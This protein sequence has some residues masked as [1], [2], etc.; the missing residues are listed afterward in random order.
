MWKY[1][2][3]IAALLTSIVSSAAPAPA[4][5]ADHFLNGEMPVVDQAHAP[6][7]RTRCFTEFALLHSGVTKTPLWSAE[8]LTP[9]R[10]KAAGKLKRVNSFH[11]EATLPLQERSELSDYARSG[12]DRGHMS[13]SGDMATAKAQRESF[14]LANM[15]PQNPCNNEVLWEGIESAVRKLALRRTDLYVVT[16]PIFD[17]QTTGVIGSGVMVP[18]RIYKAVYDPSVGQA[19]VYVTINKEDSPVNFVS[20]EQL[21]QL[22]GIDVFPNL[23]ASTKNSQMALPSP[24]P[25]K[26]KCRQH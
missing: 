7:T 23:P 26:F 13:P 6:Q 5:C 2:Y 22:T 11:P 3:L 1:L 24:Q 4:G 19:G 25:P 18:T 9:D 12:F 16:G 21:R 8:H 10:L 15:I 20:V 14:S 17:G